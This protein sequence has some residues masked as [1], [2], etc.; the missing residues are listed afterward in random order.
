MRLFY[1]NKKTEY[2]T[3]ESLNKSSDIL[4]I[5]PVSMGI[6]TLKCWHD[7]FYQAGNSWMFLLFGTVSLI[8]RI[9]LLLCWKYLWVKCLGILKMFNNTKG[10]RKVETG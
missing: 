4:I 3:T 2:Y 5:T 6:Y 10:G 1:Q 9:A 8:R 7:G